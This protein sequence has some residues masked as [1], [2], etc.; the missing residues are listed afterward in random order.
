MPVRIRHIG[1][2]R[3]E[4][5]ALRACDTYEMA[6]GHDSARLLRAEALKWL[7]QWSPDLFPYIA[8][9]HLSDYPDDELQDTEN[10]P[11]NT[12]F[13]LLANGD[14]FPLIYQWLRANAGSA[15]LPRVFELFTGAPT[16]IVSR[17]VE[18][19]VGDALAAGDEPMC[20]LLAES[21]VGREIEAAYGALASM[22]AAKKISLELHAYLAM[23]L[24]GTNRPPLLAIL[25][26]EL[27]RGRRRDTI[28]EA[29][30]IRTTPE[31][32]AI[33]KR[34]DERE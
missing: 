27:F 22:L 23:L 24:A 15:H 31:Q 7:A 13:Q 17:F 21:I 34:W 26:H 25:E 11:S 12:A 18:H 5:I 28:I 33:L 10:E 29:L 16:A 30:H 8:L 6:F 9:E 20:T 2:T 3:D 19:A 32:A 1:D 14:D 4:A